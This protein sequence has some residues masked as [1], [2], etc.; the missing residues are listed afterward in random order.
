MLD[1]LFSDRI[2]VHVVKFLEH[3][4]VGVDVEIVIAPLPETPQQ[5]FVLRKMQAE[6][7]FRSTFPCT[8]AARKSLLEDLDDFRGSDRSAF[9]DEQMEMFWHDDIADQS[10]AVASADFLEDL[11]GKIPGAGG[12]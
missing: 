5:V 3:L 10:E 6:L 1:E 2:G 7:A 4:C 9:A 8:H 11:H 12:G